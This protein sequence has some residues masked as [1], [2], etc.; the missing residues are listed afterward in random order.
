QLVELF[1]P[2]DEIVEVDLLFVPVVSADAP[3]EADEPAKHPAEKIRL[4]LQEEIGAAARLDR[5]ILGVQ[6]VEDR[7]ERDAT[8][9][10][11]RHL[12]VL[13]A[14]LYMGL[15]NRLRD[16]SRL[17]VRVR[18][19]PDGDLGAVMRWPVLLHRLLQA[20]L[21]LLRAPVCV[22]DDHRTGSAVPLDL[23]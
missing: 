4:R 1:V 15:A 12:L 20:S 2:S 11:H 14:V 6:R 3:L 21:N 19:H 23:E 17:C 5:N 7:R 13:I 22:L 9:N 10:E 8:A 18:L 16:N